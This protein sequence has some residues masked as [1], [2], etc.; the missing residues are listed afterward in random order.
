MRISI[1][2][3]WCFMRIKLPKN[4]KFIID[5]L[6]ENGY[7]CYAVGGCVRDA[8]LGREP[9]DWDLT[10]AALP[11]DIER[12]FADCRLVD[13]GKKYGTI[14]VILDGEQYEITTYRIDGDY[15]DSRHPDEVRFS[16]SLTDDLSRRDFTINA[17]A[18]NDADGLIDPFGGQRD[19]EYGVLR[20]VGVASER[21]SEDALRILRALRFA[22]TLGFS[23]EPYT[24]EAI[25]KGRKLLSEIASERISSELLKLLCGDK[26]D[27]VLRRYRTVFAVFI[28]EI[29]GTFDF[30]QNNKHHNRDVYRHTVAAVKNIEPDPILRTTMLF[31]DIGKPLACVVDKHGVSHYKNHPNLGAAMTEEILRRLCMPRYFINAVCTLIRYHDLRLKPEPAEIKRYMNTL[32]LDTMRKLMKIHLADALA[33]SMYM[34]EEKI[35]N[36]EAV[37]NELERI[38]AS[39]ECYNLSMLAV[40]GSDI[41]HLGVTSGVRI[42]EIL[43]ALLEKV[44]T[45]ELPNEKDAL[46]AAAKE[47]AA[48]EER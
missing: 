32:G 39:G 47:L 26:V 35:E 15:S 3:G 12:A 7:P 44:I 45:E 14:A 9:H 20:C 13:I 48:S 33:Q 43:N 8:V 6:G 28:P 36:I 17:M 34:R 30:E 25:L 29:Q 27:F 38:A 18:Y 37:K 1:I 23:I 46:T 24:S 11:D 10:T 21:F 5:R 41:I 4:V 42:G 22:S 40:N 2:I 31:H 16:A 19:L